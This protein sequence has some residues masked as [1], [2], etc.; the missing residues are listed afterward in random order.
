VSVLAE[1]YD[2][3][4]QRVAAGRGSEA[5]TKQE[6]IRHW[7]L[8]EAPDKFRFGDVRKAVIGVGDQTIRLVL[9]TLRDEGAIESMGTGPGAYWRRLD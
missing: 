7:V 5:G 1:S 4:E 8:N 3:F 9:R 2:D 6:R